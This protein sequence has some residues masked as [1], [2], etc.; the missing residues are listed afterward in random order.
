MIPLPFRQRLF[1]VCLSVL[2]VPL[3]AGAQ[4]PMTQPL[5][6]PPQAGP[7]L[8]NA[9]REVTHQPHTAVQQP[10]TPAAAAEAR[11]KLRE[12]I[13][14]IRNRKLAEVIQP[15]PA[16]MLKLAE[17]A[18]KVEEQL[19]QTRQQAQTTRKDL[20]K[21]TQAPKP[22]EANVSRLT[23][24]LIAQRVK[25]QEIEAAREAAVRGVLKP[26]EFA[27]LVLAW[28]KINREIRQEI[29]RVLLKKAARDDDI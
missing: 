1:G 18:E 2:T 24:Q 27:K 22:D 26:V 10:K 20:L 16:T 25:L 28:P 29:Y 13:R 11:T 21:A 5:T 23:Q 9:P 17:I 7:T 19:E 3:A 14:A 8:R 6:A 4:T 12:K 15:D